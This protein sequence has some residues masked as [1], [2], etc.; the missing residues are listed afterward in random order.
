MKRFL[1]AYISG[2]VI[3]SIGLFIVFRA[4]ART[5]VHH[6]MGVEVSSNEESGDSEISDP[7]YEPSDDELIMDFIEDQE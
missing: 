1:W 6:F 7:N 2:I 3:L 4:V 5:D